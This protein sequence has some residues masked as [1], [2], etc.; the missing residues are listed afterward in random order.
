MNLLKALFA[1]SNTKEREML[2]RVIQH[3]ADIIE[4]EEK[5]SRKDA[6]YLAIC[7]VLDDLATRPNGQNGH[8]TVMDI[9]SNEYA[10]HRND[11]ITYLAVQSGAIKLKPEFEQQ[12]IERLKKN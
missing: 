9:L 1:S 2:L 7:L 4:R 8:K 11:V 12:M 10:Q 6:E 5:R 3:N